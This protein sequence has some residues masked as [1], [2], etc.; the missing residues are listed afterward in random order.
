M[1]RSDQQ[2]MVTVRNPECLS[3]RA[4]GTLPN[5]DNDSRLEG[6]DENTLDR[7]E[8]I[9]RKLEKASTWV[10]INYDSKTVERVALKPA[11]NAR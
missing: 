11:Q 10:E 9:A 4:K 3:R 7:K 1:H 5:S 8:S 6:H 2:L